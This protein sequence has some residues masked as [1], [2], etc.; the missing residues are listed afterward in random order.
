[1]LLSLRGHRLQDGGQNGQNALQSFIISRL[2]PQSHSNLFLA[3]TPA[4]LWRAAGAVLS[5]PQQ[6]SQDQ[7][8][9]RVRL[10]RVCVQVHP[11]GECVW[12]CEGQHLDVEQLQ[13]RLQLVRRALRRRGAVD[14]LLQAGGFLAGFLAAPLS[15]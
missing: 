6:L 11:P 13:G 9:A 14:Q 10:L 8:A 4:V 2:L 1:M 5:R 7:R 12:G 15:T 3:F